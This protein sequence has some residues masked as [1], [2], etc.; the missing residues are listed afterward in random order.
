MKRLAP[1]ALLLAIVAGPSFAGGILFDLPVLTWPG[2][3]AT[4]TLGT[5]TPAPRP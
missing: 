2:D 5:K 1:L 4:A 3:D